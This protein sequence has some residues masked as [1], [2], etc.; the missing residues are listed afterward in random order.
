MDEKPRIGYRNTDLDLI[1]D[2]DPALLVNEL[3]ARA[4]VAIVTPADD[5]LF[6]VLC[7]DC[8]DLEPEPNVIRLLD[9]IDSLSE[10]ARAIWERCSKKEFDLGYDCGD[11]PWGFNQSLSNT[12]LR[13]MAACGASF[14]I[15]I[16]PYRSDDEGKCIERDLPDDGHDSEI[17]DET[18]D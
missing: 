14:R 1:C 16:Y 2:V 9:A 4:L 15:T 7:E 6:Y 12:T 8:N 13:R 18:D 10:P 3:E 11:E 5:G 17:V